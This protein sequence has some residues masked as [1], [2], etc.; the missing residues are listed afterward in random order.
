M[1][2]W[3]REKRAP[4]RPDETGLILHASTPLESGLDLSPPLPAFASS[5]PPPNPVST[6][7]GLE[8]LSS[9]ALVLYPCVVLSFVAFCYFA[10]EGEQPT[11]LHAS[12]ST[13]TLPLCA[14][15]VC[16]SIAGH[17]T[18]PKAKTTPQM[19]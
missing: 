12:G 18:L 11:F 3:K 6:T 4:A 14:R 2:R 5:P 15:G 17:G 1:W 7:G 9:T 10:A 19:R 8:N 16:V 13:L